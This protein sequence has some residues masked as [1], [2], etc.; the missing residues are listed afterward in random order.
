MPAANFINHI[1]AVCLSMI[2]NVNQCFYYLFFI[3]NTLIGFGLN[4]KSKLSEQDTGK[5][6]VLNL[7]LQKN[8]TMICQ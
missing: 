5:L 4:S 3:R 1:E 2:K 6:V 7:P 8:V